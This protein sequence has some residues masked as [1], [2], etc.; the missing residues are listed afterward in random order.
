[1]K[2]TNREKE[3]RCCIVTG[4]HLMGKYLWQVIIF[5]F[6]RAFC[7]FRG[8]LITSDIVVSVVNY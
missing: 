7:A 1:M 5:E 8:Q 6:F 4:I 3:I 2:N